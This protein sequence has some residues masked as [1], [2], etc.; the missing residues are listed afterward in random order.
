MAL[1]THLLAIM[2]YNFFTATPEH[3]VIT[4]LKEIALAKTLDL[5]RDLAGLAWCSKERV[6]IELGR[7]YVSKRISDL[8]RK[9]LVTNYRNTGAMKS[10]HKFGCFYVAQKCREVDV[11]F[12]LKYVE[13]FIAI[14]GVLKYWAWNT[15]H[16]AVV[17]HLTVYTNVPS[18][19]HDTRYTL[20]NI[21]EGIEYFGV[22]LDTCL[23]PFFGTPV[24]EQYDHGYGWPVVK[25]LREQL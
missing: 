10:Q 14:D 21:R 23:V 13:G 22:E 24:L 5:D 1:A 20:G 16:G 4:R 17:D 7:P 3:W 15:F 19:G 8:D 25:T 12:E 6:V 9:I 2:F 11:T 18:A